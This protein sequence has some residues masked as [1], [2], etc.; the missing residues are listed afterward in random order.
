MNELRRIGLNVA[1]L[2]H[3][4]GDE[5]LVE[6]LNDKFK[7][8]IDVFRPQNPLV[9]KDPLG[10]ARIV[11]RSRFHGFLG[12]LS[13]GT[14]AIGLG[15]SHK[16]REMF[17]QFG[18]PESLV[19]SAKDLRAVLEWVL[20]NDVNTGVAQKLSGA[21]DALRLQLADMLDTISFDIRDHR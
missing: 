9:V 21:A 20:A 13:A 17:E 18:M 1:F 11:L 7:G 2:Q 19:E 3:S 6:N 14:P 16:Y 8:D 4:G 5:E 12:A 15:W 10:Q